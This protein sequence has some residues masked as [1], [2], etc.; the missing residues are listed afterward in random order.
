MN[1]HWTNESS[2]DFMFAVAMDFLTELDRVMDE[3]EI[4]QR[5][6]AKRLGISEGR[7]SQ[8]VNNPGNLTLRSVVE[9]ARA[10]EMKVALVAYDDGDRNNA[11]GP[12]FS[13]VF[14]ECWKALG[15]PIDG[16]SL[17]AALGNSSCSVTV[18]MDSTRTSS[19]SQST[20][21]SN[22]G[23]KPHECDHPWLQSVQSDNDEFKLVA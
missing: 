9:W 10:L 1:R 5:D 15:K 14:H 4:S 11:H 16:W 17:E 20:E 13:G 21:M 12:V 22:V 2:K 8:V 18:E 3:R 6:L 23:G 7:V 19:H